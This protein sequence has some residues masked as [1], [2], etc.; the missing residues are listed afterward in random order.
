MLK[1][2]SAINFVKILADWKKKEKKKEKSN[3]LHSPMV[4]NVHI[5]H[6]AWMRSDENC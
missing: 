3:S 5:T 4:S 6:K 1:F 2:Q